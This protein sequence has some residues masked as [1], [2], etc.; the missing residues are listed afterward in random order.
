[1]DFL[2]PFLCLIIA[3]YSPVN[4]VQFVLIYFYISYLWLIVPEKN[5]I[6]FS[7]RKYKKKNL[8]KKKL[9]CCFFF[10]Q[11][12]SLRSKFFYFNNQ[13]FRV[14]LIF[15]QTSSTYFFKYGSDVFMLESESPFDS[16]FN[17]WHFMVIYYFSALIHKIYTELPNFIKKK[18]WDHKP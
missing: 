1:M 10:N 18:E 7:Y 16:K 4:S 2:I 8:I 15:A 12:N 11:C 5:K 6:S 3:K 17:L 9:L 14:L 13:I